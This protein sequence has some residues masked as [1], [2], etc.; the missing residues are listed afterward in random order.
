M[1]VIDFRFFSRMQINTNIY[2]QPI[3]RTMTHVQGI[4]E[5]ASYKMHPYVAMSAITHKMPQTRYGDW[6]MIEFLLSSMTFLM[7]AISSIAVC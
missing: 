2:T 1:K 6:Y 7:N 3:A 4:I 5:L